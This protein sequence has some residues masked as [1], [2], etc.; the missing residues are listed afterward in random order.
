MDKVALAGMEEDCLTEVKNGGARLDVTQTAEHYLLHPDY[1]TRVTYH[2]ARIFERRGP[3]MRMARLL[4]EKMRDEGVNFEEIQTLIGIRS[5][6]LMLADELQH[7]PELE[8]TRL[9]FIDRNREGKLVFR[10]GFSLDDDERVFILDDLAVTYGTFRTVIS[11]IRTVYPDAFII[12]FAPFIDRSPPDIRSPKQFA[13][14]F[15]Y[16]CGL[17][18]A[19]YIY[20]PGNRGCPY[21][22]IGIP[23]VKA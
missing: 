16:T 11:L 3:R 8:H 12:G 15:R 18:L 17:R 6:G 21:C 2:L 13:P 4:L 7:F 1:H 19:S 23:L 9:L 5:R 10:S 22:K 14:T 20:D